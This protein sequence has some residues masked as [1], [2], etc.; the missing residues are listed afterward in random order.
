VADSTHYSDCL[1]IAKSK[2]KQSLSLKS[3]L[4]R[5]LVEGH[6]LASL[7]R[8]ELAP[9]ATGGQASVGSSKMMVSTSQCTT[10]SV[11]EGTR[12]TLVK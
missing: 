5:W 12:R 6:I 8:P 9:E 4:R 7:G 2:R 3:H 11:C 10:K 1:H